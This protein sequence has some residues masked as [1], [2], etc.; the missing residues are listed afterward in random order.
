MMCV[1]TANDY[2]PIIGT[3]EVFE[4]SFST[5]HDIQF[6]F[7]DHEDESEIVLGGLKIF[8][9]INKAIVVSGSVRVEPGNAKCLVV[10]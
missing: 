10:I 2:H 3:V 8:V 6:L 4:D 1:N 5:E 7:F 9:P